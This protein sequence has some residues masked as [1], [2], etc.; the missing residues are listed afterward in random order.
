MFGAGA[1]AWNGSTVS[2]WWREV[3][4]QGTVQMCLILSTAACG[5]R[6]ASAASSACGTVQSGL[7]PV[8]WA[9]PYRL[10]CSS[11][12]EAHH[13]H[14]HLIVLQPGRGP[15][16]APQHQLA[17]PHHAHSLSP[18]S[19]RSLEECPPWVLTQT[20]CVLQALG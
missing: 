3:E 13:H 20:W 12:A 2:S 10:Y 16:A 11:P 19:S 14:F 7:V 9:Q 18:R 15:A 6:L 17:P 8:L 5:L 4:G 1:N